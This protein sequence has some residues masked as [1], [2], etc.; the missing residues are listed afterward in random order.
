MAPI[1]ILYTIAS[2][3]GIAAGIPQLRKLIATKQSDEFSVVTW[4]TWGVVQC[5]SLLYA[6]EVKATLY[7]AICVVW[8]V[9]YIVMVVLIIK[10]RQPK[11]VFIAEPIDEVG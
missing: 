5:I 4:M 8:I 2:I 6:L 11:T 3:A 7:A 10:Y 1:F 9:F